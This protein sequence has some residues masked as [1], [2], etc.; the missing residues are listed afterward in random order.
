MSTVTESEK[1]ILAL[2]KKLEELTDEKVS[3]E[4]ELETLRSE[5]NSWKERYS[6]LSENVLRMGKNPEQLTA[7]IEEKPKPKS[8]MSS[9]S[10]DLEKLGIP[11]GLAVKIAIEKDLIKRGSRM[12]PGTYPSDSE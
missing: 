5:L 7:T 8:R 2:S 4:I 10:Q 1:K 12:Q 3:L 9:S 6:T 11:V